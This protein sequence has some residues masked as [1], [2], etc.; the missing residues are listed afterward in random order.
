MIV[1]FIADRCL[2]STSVASIT[3]SLALGSAEKSLKF[4]SGIRQLWPNA[5]RVLLQSRT[6]NV[7]LISSFHLSIEPNV[8]SEVHAHAPVVPVVSLPSRGESRLL[9]TWDSDCVRVFERTHCFPREQ[10][11]RKQHSRIATGSVACLDE[12]GRKFRRRRLCLGYCKRA[13]FRRALL[14]PFQNAPAARVILP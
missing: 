2:K 3:V 1:Q 12:I 14:S 9:C 8:S 7:L 13:F 11:F 6:V 4:F 5:T 10:D